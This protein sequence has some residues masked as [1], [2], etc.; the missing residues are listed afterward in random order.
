MFTRSCDPFSC[1]LNIISDYLVDLFYKGLEYRTINSH[2]SAFS[3]THLQIDSVCVGTHPFISRPHR[4]IASSTVS[5]WLKYVLKLVGIDVYKGHST[6]SVAAS[7]AKLE[8]VSSSDILKVADWS[9]ET[10]FIR[11]YNRPLD[12]V[13]VG[14]NLL[15]QN[16]Q[17][18]LYS[19]KVTSKRGR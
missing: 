13:D 11:F 16:W 2:G 10:T 18:M 9:R 5:R 12:N 4:P 1:S 15:S 17:V 3:M 8:G 7:A 6:G 14:I 19:A